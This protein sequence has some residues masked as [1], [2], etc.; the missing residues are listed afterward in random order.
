MTIAELREL[1]DT[2]FECF[3]PD[4]DDPE[5]V[6]FAVPIPSPYGD[7]LEYFKGED[8]SITIIG[9]PSVWENAWK[10]YISSLTPKRKNRTRKQAANQGAITEMPKRLALITLPPYQ[11]AMTPIEDKTAHLQP[12]IQSFAEV[13]Q[14]N[15]DTMQAQGEIDSIPF[16]QYYDNSP[17]AVS[18]LDLTTLRAIYS[19]FLSNAQ[20]MAENPDDFIRRATSPGFDKESVTLYIPEFLRMT[21]LT[22]NHNRSNENAVLSKIASYAPIYGV[23]EEKSGGR[24][25][26]N[27][28]PVLQ[29]VKHNEARNTVEI[30]SPYFHALIAKIV[31]ASV[32]KDSHDKPKLRKNGKPFTLPTHSYL[33]KAEIVKE[34]NQRAAEIV[35]VVVTLIAQ[36]GDGGTPHIKAQTIVDRCPDLKNTLENEKTS[37]GKSRVLRRAFAK[38]W[39][40]LETKTELRSHYKNIQFPT[41]V[42]TSST[43]DM[44]IEFPHEGKIIKPEKESQTS[45]FR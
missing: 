38:A 5:S 35:C 6:C 20:K 23:L 3:M 1:T 26:R 21:G 14:K 33:V 36:C 8:G 10:Q 43:L 16:V 25:Y 13:L 37:S 17:Q 41:A 40:L 4:D 31:Q 39:Q 29:L 12:L 44:V 28:Y 42:P 24:T 15:Y 45:I 32:K 2:P 27:H 11:N 9:D 18:N 22:P 30:M 19:V 7:G 34:R